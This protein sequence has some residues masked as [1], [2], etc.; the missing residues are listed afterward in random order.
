MRII[1]GIMALGI[2]A[3]ELRTPLTAELKT[4]TGALFI[5]RSNALVEVVAEKRTS[6]MHVQR[7]GVAVDTVMVQVGAAQ[8]Q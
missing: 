4:P 2:A 5:Q 1:R 6:Q 3:M 8:P 7:S